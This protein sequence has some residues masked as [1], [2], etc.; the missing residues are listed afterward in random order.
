MHGLLITCLIFTI[1]ARDSE[2]RDESV[3]ITDF[4]WGVTLG[5][6]GSD[7][8]DVAGLRNFGVGGSEM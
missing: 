2:I 8:G 3:L 1:P 7:W 4:F 5:E 6:L